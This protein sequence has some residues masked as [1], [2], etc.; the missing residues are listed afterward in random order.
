MRSHRVTP[1]RGHRAARHRG[2]TVGGSDA[3]G[4]PIARKAAIVVPDTMHDDGELCATATVRGTG[5]IRVP[6][7]RRAVVALRV[8]MAFGT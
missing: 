6:S 8:R 5:R 2:G 4:Q 1:R 3:G 7:A